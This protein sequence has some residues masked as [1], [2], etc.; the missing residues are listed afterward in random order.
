MYVLCAEQQEVFVTPPQAMPFMHEQSVKHIYVVRQ[1]HITIMVSV[2]VKS[3]SESCRTS[4]LLLSGIKQAA[5]EN[6]CHLGMG[7]IIAAG[8]GKAQHAFLQCNNQ[9]SSESR[10]VQQLCVVLLLLNRCVLVAAC[11]HA[12]KANAQLN[13]LKIIHHAIPSVSYFEH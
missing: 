1:L 2:A 13:G 11:T 9:L 4:W 6:L 8:I 12:I 10:N 5:I 7:Q 3:C